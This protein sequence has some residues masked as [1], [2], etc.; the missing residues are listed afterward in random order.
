M[1]RKLGVTTFQFA[2]MTV[3][4]FGTQI[5]V[6]ADAALKEAIDTGEFGAALALAEKLPTGER[7][8]ALQ[9]IAV[10]QVKSGDRA[11]AL[12]TTSKIDDDRAVANAISSVRKT[13]LGSGGARGGS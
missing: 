12:K 3:L 7:D 13:P 1:V 9:S 10:A 4:L 8:T 6:A 11:A 2:A 5:S